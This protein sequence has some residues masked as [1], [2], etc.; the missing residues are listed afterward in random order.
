[1]RS[2]RRRGKCPAWGTAA[3]AIS[4]TELGDLK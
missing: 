2:N 3:R 1:M 4:L